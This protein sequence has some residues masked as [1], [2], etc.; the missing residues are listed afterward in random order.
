MKI[1]A[2]LIVVGSLMLIGA[3]TADS[4]TFDTD[5]IGD[6]IAGCLWRGEAV[7][8][9]EIQEM[10]EALKGQ[11]LISKRSGLNR[12]G[13]DSSS[14]SSIEEVFGELIMET[15]GNVDEGQ[16]KQNVDKFTH[17]ITD[18]REDPEIVEAALS[19]IIGKF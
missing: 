12:Q 15:L 1:T 7:P 13:S 11:D 14:G 18:L 16:K 9:K 2:C 17:T 3:Q 8:E 10:F 5:V 4:S 19:I 6:H